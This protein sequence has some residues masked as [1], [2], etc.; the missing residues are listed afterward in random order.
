MCVPCSTPGPETTRNETLCAANTAR[1]RKGAALLRLPADELARV[2]PELRAEARK[3]IVRKVMHVMEAFQRF[4]VHELDQLVGNDFAR[5]KVCFV[6]CW[7]NKESLN[8]E[9]STFEPG[10]AFASINPELDLLAFGLQGLD[11]LLQGKQQ[12]AVVGAT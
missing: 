2:A 12:A 7:L 6:E 11:V 10:V 4:N 1:L 5:C 3:C 9:T 8:F